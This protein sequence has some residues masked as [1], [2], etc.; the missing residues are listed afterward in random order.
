MSARESII[1]AAIFDLDGVIVDTAKYH[2][3]AW[4]KLANEIGTDLSVEE[5]ERLKGVSRMDSLDIILSLGGLQFSEVEKVAMADKKNTWFV[6]YVN[7]MKPDEILPGAKN[8]LES[9]RANGIKVALGSS[10]KNAKAVLDLLKI[11]HLFDVIVDG[12]MIKKSK[13]DPEIFLLG[14]SLLNIPPDQCIV[15]ED[16]EAGVEAALAANMRCIGLG[17][18]AQL[19]KANLVIPDLKNFTIEDMINLVPIH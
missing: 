18:P 5:N 6:D 13:P 12:T 16:A 17:S 19:G 9:C 8:L 4:K 3:L 2:Y 10:S 14:A 15:F 7:Q 1:S 11:A